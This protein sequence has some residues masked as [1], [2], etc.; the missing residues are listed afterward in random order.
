MCW[1]LWTK[2]HSIKSFSS[3]KYAQLT[4][5]KVRSKLKLNHGKALLLDLI[6]YISITKESMNI[7]TVYGKNV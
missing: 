1:S 7:I 5:V 3:I 4:S 6:S 2:G